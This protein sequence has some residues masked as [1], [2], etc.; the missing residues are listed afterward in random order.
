MKKTVLVDDHPIFRKGVKHLLGISQRFYVGYEASSCTALRHFLE[1]NN[2]SLSEVFFVIDISL[3]DGNGFDLVPPIVAAGGRPEHCAILSMHEE[4]E[5]AQRAFALGAR[6]YVVKS[7]DPY[8]II[9]CLEAMERG[10]QY[11]SAGAKRLHQ[12]TSGLSVADEGKSPN[13]AEGS[14]PDLSL[15]SERERAVLRL[16]AAG[17]TSKEI[18]E[19]LFLS[20]RTVENHR[21]RMSRKLGL[22][23][24]NALIALAIA[25]RDKLGF[26]H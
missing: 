17:H 4:Y 15:L 7:D 24:A 13:T 11:V 16:V 14:L 19:K 2:E 26:D 12:S 22:T 5:Y 1:G 9:H 18:S 23:G 8:S 25:Q 10:E 3:P 20:H 21:A 6:G